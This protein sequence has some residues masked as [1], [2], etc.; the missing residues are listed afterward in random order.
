M[1]GAYLVTWTVLCFQFHTHR[2]LQHSKAR[3]YSQTVAELRLSVHDLY[4]SKPRPFAR[5][6]VDTSAHARIF[7]PNVYTLEN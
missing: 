3:R 1:G 4:P 7:S 2:T 5:T 6:E